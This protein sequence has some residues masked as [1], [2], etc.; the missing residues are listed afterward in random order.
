MSAGGHS[1]HKKDWL[2]LGATAGLAATGLGAA[3][4]GPM[5]GL[6]GSAAPFAG[7]GAAAAAA[8]G[9]PALLG[10]GLGGASLG[11]D[12]A[13][14]VAAPV[15]LGSVRDLLGGGRGKGLLRGAMYANNA[16][17]PQGPPAGMSMQRPQPQG[18]FPNTMLIAQPKGT[19]S[20]PG[21]TG[22]MFNYDTSND[23][24]DAYRKWLMQQQG[25][26]I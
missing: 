22:G 8:E 4:I 11:A 23:P 24:N 9:S 16:M 12:A 3:G 6:L 26:Q 5:A 10:A 2:T 7:A 14:G 18:Q 25:G 21:I 17:Q 15:E 19:I 13:S 20:A 1:L